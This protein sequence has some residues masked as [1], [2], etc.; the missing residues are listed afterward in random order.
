MD[1][2][3][4]AA[5]IT[6]QMQ[7]GNVVLFL[8]AGVNGGSTNRRQETLANTKQLCE[9]LASEIGENYEGESL[10]DV[11]L[12]VEHSLGRDGLN[13]VLVNEFRFCTAS[14]AIQQMLKY[15]W[16]RVYTWNYDDAVIAI[17]GNAAQ[18]V[19]F[20]NGMRDAVEDVDDPSV[21]QYIFLHGMITKLDQGIILTE[22]D[23]A[24]A[25]QRDNNLWYR[26]A[27]QDYR[28][29]PVVLIGTSLNEPILAAELERASRSGIGENGLA[30]LITPDKLSGIRRKSFLQRGIVHVEGTIDTF[31]SWLE[32]NIGPELTPKQLL[33][34]DKFFNEKNIG[35]F[36]AADLRAAHSIR[37][38]IQS[39][40]KDDFDRL[41][42]T[43]QNATAR[44]FL[45]G[46]PPTWMLAASKIPV[47]LKQV[48][49]LKSSMA[50]W[51]ANDSELFLTVGQAGSGKSTATMQVLLELSG[52]KDFDLFELSADTKSVSDALNVLA[53]L[54]DRRKIVYLPNL[55]VFGV[56]LEGDLETARRANVRLVSTA[57]SSEWKE[58]FEKHFLN[59]A[60]IFKFQR[61]EQEDYA[62]LIEKLKTYVPAPKFMKLKYDQQVDRLQRSKSQLLIALR[63][64]TESKNFEEIIISEFKALADDDVRELFVI[65]GLATLARVGILPE[66]A[67][68]AYNATTRARSF[69]DALVKLE[70]IVAPGSSG[71]LI[72]RHEFYVRNI[73]DTT[74]PVGTTLGLL[75]RTLG[76]FTKYDIPIS[77]HVGRQDSALFRFLLNHGFIRERAERG[78]D[79]YAGLEVY[80]SFEV[81]FQL[82]GHFWLQYGLY[83]QRL[84]DLSMALRM[85]EKSVEAFP[86]NPFAVHALASQRLF[87]AGRRPDYDRVTQNLIKSGVEDLERLDAKQELTIDQY[88]LVTLSRIVVPVLL[89]HGQ[90]AKAREY[91]TNYF[92]RLKVFERNVR[93][94]EVT[95]A[96]MKL[97]KFLTSGIWEN[98]RS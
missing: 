38:L 62:P 26:K 81:P 39:V 79:K 69:D 61:F 83:Y 92:E 41:G 1:F 34:R 95:E 14:P 35:R 4:N 13:K 72:A 94:H 33:E 98:E 25:L 51:F 66:V 87:E 28:G 63:E 68:E 9:A 67:A 75:E 89:H 32:K 59:K 8:G 21:L 22:Q 30:I 84:N 36:S 86:G 3:D 76:T 93:S 74:V 64:A 31:V 60:T 56:G 24:D 48:D 16:K 91:A 6:A 82:D 57:R 46:F 55:F 43:T 65:V 50:Q 15:T 88:P 47:R 40:L 45:N 78:G 7:K 2:G 5:L 97:L 11:A 10:S 27:T 23:Y 17:A 58:H 73:L 77:K 12:S 90:A 85:L 49:E 54:S 71:R 70:G 42:T 44:S 96:K 20:Y 29:H 37:P 52:E 18:R 53:R 19:E 80:K